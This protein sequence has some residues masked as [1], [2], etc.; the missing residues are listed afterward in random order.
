VLE[1]MEIE[2]ENTRDNKLIDAVSDARSF[3]QRQIQR[4]RVSDNGIQPSKSRT[5]GR[6]LLIIVSCCSSLYRHQRGVDSLIGEHQLSA[7]SRAINFVP[8]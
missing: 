1:E 4:E 3:L 7:P 8:L 5:R 6:T 2:T